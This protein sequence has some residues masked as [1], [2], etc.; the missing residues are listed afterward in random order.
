ML[1]GVGHVLQISI[2]KQ[3]ISLKKETVL[4]L[5]R[6]SISR[7]LFLNVFEKQTKI[8]SDFCTLITE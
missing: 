3:V 1:I 6:E 4:R 7:T 5:L 2:V 8:E